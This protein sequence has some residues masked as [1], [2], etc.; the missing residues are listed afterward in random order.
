MCSTRNNQ[1]IHRTPSLSSRTTTSV[2]N[3]MSTYSKEKPPPFSTNS[4]I[5][6]LVVLNDLTDIIQ[7][8][9]RKDETNIATNVWQHPLQLWMLFKMASDCLP[10]G[11]VLAHDNGCPP[12]KRDTDLLH[13]LGANIVNIDHEE[14]W[15][16]VK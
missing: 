3:Y 10:D 6:Y 7:V 1:K 11:G 8:F 12:S 13:L 16:L 15:I 5:A 14:P 4:I 9:L 2:D